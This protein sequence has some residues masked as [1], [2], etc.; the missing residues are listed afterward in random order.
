MS[1]V[2]PGHKYKFVTIEW[3]DS[4]R[5]DNDWVYTKDYKHPKPT[6]CYTTGYIIYEDKHFVSIAQT[7]A[8]VDDPDDSEQV[9]GLMQ[10]PKCAIMFTRFHDEQYKGIQE[11]GGE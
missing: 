4:R 9:M 10:I 11:E 5:P 6:Y 1:G 8:D 2:Y 3:L 7:I